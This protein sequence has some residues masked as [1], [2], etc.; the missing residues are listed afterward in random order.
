MLRLADLPPRVREIVLEEVAAAAFRDLKFAPT[1]EQVLGTGQ[2]R[3]ISRTR[4]AIFARC[5]WELQING[6][7]ATYPWIG[8]TFGGYDHTS[9]I[10]AVRQHQKRLVEWAEAKQKLYEHRRRQHIVEAARQNEHIS[11]DHVAE[12][13]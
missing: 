8:K 1:V 10:S 3:A 11:A 4:A 5:R 9:V 7:P 12:A 2:A 6:R 13:A